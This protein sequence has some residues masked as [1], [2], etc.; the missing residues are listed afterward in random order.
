MLVADEATESFLGPNELSCVIKGGPNLFPLPEKRSEAG[1]RLAK[2]SARIRDGPI[3]NEMVFLEFL[4]ELFK[5]HCVLAFA[6]DRLMRCFVAAVHHHC[7]EIR[8]R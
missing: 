5:R 7:V 6:R 4:I 8:W 2:T 3:T 1:L